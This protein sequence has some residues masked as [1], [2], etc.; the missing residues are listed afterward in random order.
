M[1]KGRI[2]FLHGFTQSSSIFYAKTSALRKKL[3]KLNYEI[4]Y[5][6]AP[7]RLTPADFPSREALSKFG[8]VTAQNDEETNYRA[9]W[10]K[11]SGSI[12][13]Q[14]ALD[15]IEK[16]LNTGEVHEDDDSIGKKHLTSIPKDDTPVVGIIGF[17]QG[18]AFAGII[19]R[20]FKQLFEAHHLKFVVSYSGFKLP[21]ED[22]AKYYSYVDGEKDDFKMLQV[23][24]E[25]DTVVEEKRAM[26][27]YEEYKDCSELLKHPGGHFVPN[28]KMSIDQVV[29]WI[30]H[31][32]K[33]EEEEV[34]KTK[35]KSDDLDDLMD[36]MDKLGKV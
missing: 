34:E 11:N 8:S 2:I 36:M 35:S 28:S 4:I 10:F 5:L 6:N 7:L 9:W 3:V 14:P 19:A 22:V 25:L 15:T 30:E 27:L 16:F 29:N 32:M 23:M 21:D 26:T 1:S 20:Q 24:G 33:G 13:L 17:S 12:D 18:A 31:A